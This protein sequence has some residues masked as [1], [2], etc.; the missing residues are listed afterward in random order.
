M[1]YG[2]CEMIY[3]DATRDLSQITDHT[4]HII[5]VTMKKKQQSELA[6]IVP[7]GIEF[8]SPMDRYTTFRAGGKAE[9]ICFPSELN[10]LSRLISYLHN[11]NIPYLVL[12]NGSNLLV[13]DKGI[14]GVVIVLKGDLATVEKAD[15]SDD[16]L[17]AGGGQSRET[18]VNV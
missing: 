17:M 5:N 2:M 14:E 16:I 9:L 8:D 18:S 11:E 12:G 4:S 1:G 7:H 6:G 13:K 10:M 3:A 15:G